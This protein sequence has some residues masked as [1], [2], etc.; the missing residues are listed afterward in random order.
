MLSKT[1]T[2]HIKFI[3]LSKFIKP[4]WINLHS[5]VYVQMNIFD[6]ILK[7]KSHWFRKGFHRLL[8]LATTQVF[9]N[10]GGK[11]TDHVGKVIHFMPDFY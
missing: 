11:P 10:L 2:E 3:K 8:A 9:F 6:E 7:G 4:R 1:I 5:R